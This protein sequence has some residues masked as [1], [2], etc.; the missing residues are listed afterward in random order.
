VE[1][2]GGHHV[3]ADRY[4][5]D[6]VDIFDVQDE[7]TRNIV[8]AIHPAI[9]LAEVERVRKVR[10]DN[11]D[12]WDHVQRGWAEYF[13]YD[14]EASQKAI[15]YFAYAVDLDPDYAE[16][17]A[18]LSTAH[19]LE[20][21]LRWVDDP[22]VSLEAAYAEARKAIDLDDRDATS[23]TALAIANY[24][25][26]RLQGAVAA[27]DRAI[28][29]NPSAPVAHVFGGVARIH[30]GDPET[31]IKMIE[32]AIALDPRHPMA[33]FF[34]GGKAIG[35]FLLHQLEA[36]VSSAR[37]GIAL[38]YDYLFG[39]V[40]LTASLVEMGKLDEAR[41]ELEV[42]LS[43]DPEYNPSR[44]DLYTWRLARGRARDVRIGAEPN[45]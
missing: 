9:R 13:R 22:I 14:K 33:L 17:H 1:A 41:Q 18:G 40:V 32:H 37:N 2:P 44:L 29:L 34:H 23:H 16:A 8:V 26:G 39:R 25:M 30:G 24:G 6:L 5:G 43:I 15:Q 31:G 12:A 3:W 28:E 19:A 36:S 42:I 11:M 45:S 4:D 10:P 38:R 21:W 35:H 7:I 20:A 27:A